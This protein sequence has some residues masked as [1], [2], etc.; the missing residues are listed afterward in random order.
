MYLR[1]RSSNR[2]FRAQQREKSYKQINHEPQTF[3]LSCKRAPAS[4]A[5]RPFS[6]GNLGPK[7]LSHGLSVDPG[8]SRAAA[9]G[10]AVTSAPAVRAAHAERL[11]RQ[12][13]DVTPKGRARSAPSS[14]CS[15]DSRSAH[16]PLAARRD[17]GP[18]PAPARG[19]QV[20]PREPLSSSKGHDCQRARWSVGGF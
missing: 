14:H 15:G 6:A 2:S 18:S 5:R 10:L 16:S 13:S 4:P 11:I 9:A 17:C 8:A 20:S 1:I 7:V 12:R 3:G 19:A